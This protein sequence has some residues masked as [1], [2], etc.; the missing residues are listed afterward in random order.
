MPWA[1]IGAILGSA[2]VAVT[3]VALRGR[4][5]GRGGALVDDG[6]VVWHELPWPQRCR[7][8]DA[9][10]AHRPGRSLPSDHGTRRGDWSFVRSRRLLQPYFAGERVAFDDV[11]SISSSDAVPARVAPRR[12]GRCRAARSSPTASS[13]RSPARP[14]AARAAGTFCAHNRL[15]LF[16]PCHRVVAAGGL[17]SYGSLGVGYKRR[18]LELEGCPVLSE[19]LRDELAAIAPARDCD[20]LAELSGLFHS[21]GS[22]HLRGRGEVAVHLD[23]AS[24]PSRGGRSRC[25]GRSASSPRS[26]HTRVTPSTARRA[27]SCTWREPRV[28]YEVSAR[29]GRAR[30][31]AR[32]ARAP[33]A[34]RRRAAV[35]PPRL[36]A[37]RAARRR[38]GE[39]P[40][41]A[42]PRD[43]RREPE[44]ARFS[45]GSRRTKASSSASTT[46]AD[47]AIAYAKGAEAIA[48]VLAPPAR[49]DASLALEEHAVV[50]ATRARAN[51]LANADHANLVRTSRAAHA[52]CRRS[53]ALDG[54]T[55]AAPTPLREIAELRLRHPPRRCAS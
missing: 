55:L 42:A 17:G 26:A 52:S 30:P 24:R 46:A 44:G 47:H 7:P 27:T 19:D 35:L 54:R 10:P 32:A 43:P 50:A 28:R 2:A 29:G 49:G 48:D 12:S 41:R 15:S 13:R 21:A 23:L 38:L 20:R 51:R 14:G 4:R 22:L 33:A 16:I 5:L 37:R 31:R 8:P 11:E 36:P 34:A 25:C 1:L 3:Q 45:P 6:R 53:A 40:A 9:I 39:R 18:L